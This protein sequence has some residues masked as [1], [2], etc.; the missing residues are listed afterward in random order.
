[1]A[2]VGRGLGLFF[3]TGWI[4]AVDGRRGEA[5]FIVRGCAIS[6]TGGLAGGSGLFNGLIGRVIFAWCHSRLATGREQEPV[7]PVTCP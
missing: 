2:G 3:L 1:M 4:M 7:F 5:T 6:S